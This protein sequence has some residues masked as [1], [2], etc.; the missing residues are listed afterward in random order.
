VC[1]LDKRISR[2]TLEFCPPP[3]PSP[4]PCSSDRRKCKGNRFRSADPP[5]MQECLYS[6]TP[7][8][9]SR[10][11]GPNIPRL[12]QNCFLILR[13]TDPISFEITLL[14][15]QS[16]IL[17]PRAVWHTSVKELLH[18]S[19]HQRVTTDRHDLMPSSRRS[20]FRFQ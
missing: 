1:I 8:H 2:L 6:L 20:S 13:I 19:F 14:L 18:R 9:E 4:R 7:W 17:R 15:H 10:V 16:E 5:C 3:R 11:Y 12:G